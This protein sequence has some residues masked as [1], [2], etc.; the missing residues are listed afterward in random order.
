MGL[1]GWQV[2]S[3][4]VSCIALGK[5][6]NPPG[7]LQSSKVGIR[8]GNLPPPPTASGFLVYQPRVGEM[9]PGWGYSCKTGMVAGCPLGF[10]LQL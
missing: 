8:P 9:G 2:V 5:L 7:A 10:V 6:L 3:L 4:A 1:V